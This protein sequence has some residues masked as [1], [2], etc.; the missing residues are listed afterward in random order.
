M[1]EELS[2]DK[3]IL[4]TIKAA[5]EYSNIGQGKLRELTSDPRCNFVLHSGRNVLIK[6]RRFEDYLEAREVV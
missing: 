2:I 4:L 6:R 1:K 3:K 5:A